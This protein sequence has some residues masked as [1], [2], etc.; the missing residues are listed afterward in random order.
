MPHARPAHWA[1]IVPGAA[2]VGIRAAA[3]GGL[4]ACLAVV[5]GCSGG[6][7]YGV[8]PVSG[9]ITYE[10]GSAIPAQ[11]II[12]SFRSLEPSKD[13][14]TYPRKGM[15]LVNPD[16]SFDYVTTYAHADGAI[17][18][19]HKVVVGVRDPNA[20]QLVP[21][22]YASEETTPLEVD[23]RDAPWRLLVAKPRTAK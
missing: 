21:P 11:S 15:C 13:P 14:K 17:T 18:G 22:E 16:G 12:L 10:D 23:T 1:R 5:A 4:A 8:T 9:T 19:R 20:D 7:P 2:A 3:L 6:A